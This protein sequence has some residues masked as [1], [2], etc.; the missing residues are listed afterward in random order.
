LLELW[1]VRHGETDWNAQGRVQ[2]W[3]DVPL[4]E[5]GVSQAELLSLW[6]EGIP[7]RAVVASDLI[8]ARHTA[9]ILRSR[10]KAPFVTDPLLRERS[11]GKGEG[12]LRSD[13]LRHYPNGAPEAESAA[14]VERRVMEFLSKMTKTYSDGRILC[15]SHGGVIRAILKVLNCESPT[16]LGNTSVSRTRFH[17][18]KW[19]VLAV[20]WSEHLVPATAHGEHPPDRDGDAVHG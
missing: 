16:H 3:T 6:L 14:D 8:R 5:L 7:F 19:D 10:M 15:V 9:T 13:M 17:D 1:W 18:G 11:F 4:N 12:M 20:N 2:G